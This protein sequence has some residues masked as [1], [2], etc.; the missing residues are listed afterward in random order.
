MVDLG[1]FQINTHLL[2]ATCQIITMSEVTDNVKHFIS[3]ITRIPDHSII[4][5][6][7]IVSEYICDTNL[8]NKGNEGANISNVKGY[9]I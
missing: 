9:L 5:S 3:D 2:F 1:Q 8:P 6:D 7:V 4:V